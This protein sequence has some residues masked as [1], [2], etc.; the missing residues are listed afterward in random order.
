MTFPPWFRLRRPCGVGYRHRGRETLS[1][2]SE[3][4]GLSRQIFCG[5]TDPETPEPGGQGV[6]EHDDVVEV[7]AG[8]A[9]E[10]PATGDQP[11]PRARRGAVDLLGRE[12]RLRDLGDP[13]HDERPPASVAHPHHNLRPGNELTE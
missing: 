5:G 12:R 3:L 11:E 4:P 1:A 9:V 8:G 10:R 7:V 13:R 2:G 6:R